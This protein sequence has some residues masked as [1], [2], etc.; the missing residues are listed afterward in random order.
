PQP[1]RNFAQNNIYGIDFAKEAVKIA[2]AINLIVGDG[3]S[4]IYGGGAHGNSLNPSIWNDEMKAGLRPRL[5]RFPNDPQKDRENQEKFIYF[6]F[7]VLM[8]NPPFAGTV[9]ER[10]ILK[11][12]KL[13]EKNGKLVNKI[14]RHILFL[15]RS[16]QFIRP[17]GRMAIVLPQGLLNNTNAEYI[18]R[19]V[20]D[21]ARILAVVGLHVNTFKPHTG[22]K[23]S[24]LFLQKYTDEEKEK[25]QQIRAKYE[26][27]WEEFFEK[28]KEKYKNISWESQINEEEIP[29]ELN[30]FLGSYFE[31]REEIEELSTDEVE[32][33]E[34]VEEA[35]EEKPKKK[36]LADLIKEKS[37]L[38]EVKKEK[39]EELLVANAAKKSEL[40]KEIK[41][42]QNKINKLIKEISERTLAGQISLVLTEEKITEAF[43]KFWL[44]SKVI[45]EIDYP[46]FFAVNEKPVK[47]ESG[48]YRYK[49]NPDGSFVLD[50][51]GHL[52]IDHDLDEIANAFI[53]F[54]KEQGFDFWK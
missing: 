42:L 31:S 21:E 24:V 9:K 37:E 50:E 27:E 20:I 19:F 18:R 22:T 4:H 26:G 14:G 41:I 46:I 49:K 8:T 52:V 23:T 2:K 10:E 5:L 30:T 6:D 45:K 36:P 44:D 47:D 16:L 48:E 54:A 13:A 34:E 53:E 43:K 40:R 11:L 25:I 51:H 32:E 39:E 35:E 15:E 17:G 33:T 38:E 29:E 7:D 12:Y 28:L 1:A 3:K